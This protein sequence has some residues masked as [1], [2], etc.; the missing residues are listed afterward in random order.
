MDEIGNWVYIIL[1]F[2]VLI[3]GVFKSFTKKKEQQQTQMPVPEVPEDEFP[4]PP[5]PRKMTRKL[6][7]PIPVQK[8]KPYSSLFASPS[9]TESMQTEMSFS[10]EQ[11]S[12]IADELDLTDAEAFR[13]AI[14]YSEIINRKY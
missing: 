9:V 11:E 12:V 6:P 4:V 14:I 3:S 2:V 8:N 7:P 5:V 13:R 1:M 10:P